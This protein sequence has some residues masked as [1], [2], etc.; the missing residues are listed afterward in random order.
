[1]IKYYCR[2]RKNDIEKRK[3][4]KNTIITISYNLQKKKKNQT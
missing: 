3:H 4:A 2:R 1:M